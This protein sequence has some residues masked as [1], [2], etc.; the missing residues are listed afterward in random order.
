MWWGHEFGW[1]WM[2]FGSLMMVAFWGGLIL[3]VVLAVRT[4]SGSGARQSGSSDS[5]RSD[6]ALN[7]LKERYARGEISKADY[8][9][10][11]ATL[12]T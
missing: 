5:A 9:E 2:M 1:G 12:K 10:M 8:E 3:L 6:N 11:R 7:I 4:I